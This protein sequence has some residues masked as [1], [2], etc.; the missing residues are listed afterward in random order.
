MRLLNEL[1]EAINHTRASTEEN[2]KKYRN[3]LRIAYT[4]MQ[5]AVPSTF[6]RLF[7]SYSDALSRDW[8]RISKCNERIRIVN[9]GGSAIGTSIAVP[10]YFVME[11]V[12]TLQ[13]ITG[14]PLARGEN[15]GDAT[16]NLDPLVEVH[17]ILKTHAVSLEKM[18][19]DLRIL[20]SDIIGNKEIEL[21]QKQVGSSIMPGKVN[22]VI[23]EFVISSVHRIYSNDSL[24][25]TLCAQGCLDLN[26]YL[27]VIGHAFIESIKLLIACNRSLKDHLFA[28]L[29][30]NTDIA[31][32]KVFRSPSITTSLLPYVG[33]NKAAEVAKYMKEYNTDIFGANKKMKFISNEKLTS[34][35]KPENLIQGG[36]R[37]KDLPDN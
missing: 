20:S 32:S 15:L 30:V 18:V 9:L 19:N 14:L 8:W 4:Q 24:I 33:Y 31:E 12:K 11:V 35:L 22:P 36:F 5:E 23:A 13:S 26:A 29:I 16:C 3:S 17:G 37:I 34:V 7:S 1:E 6:G 25:A 21:P 2:E 27:P 10:R 28:G